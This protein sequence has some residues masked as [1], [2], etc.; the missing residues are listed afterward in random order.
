MVTV[1][2]NLKGATTKHEQNGSS[3]GCTIWMQLRRILEQN[4]PV[5]KVGPGGHDRTLAK[6]YEERASA[7]E[8]WS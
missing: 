3:K 7:T 1:T 4:M 8:Q 5:T 2:S 6:K